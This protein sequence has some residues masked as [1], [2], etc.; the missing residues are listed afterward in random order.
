LPA[1]EPYRDRLL[2]TPR[3]FFAT[4]QLAAVVVAVTQPSAFCEADLTIQPSRA[5]LRDA[6]HEVLASSE[7]TSHPGERLHRCHS[8]GYVEF[9]N[10][11]ILLAGQRVSIAGRP[12]AEVIG[13]DES[14]LPDHIC[15]VVR[16]ESAKQSR[17]T[18]LA[19]TGQ[20][21]S[22]RTPAE[23]RRVAAHEA[24]GP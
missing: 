13:F 22:F 9:S 8:V 5:V 19:I 10:S 3:P 15:I 16:P 21:L 23:P 11:G 17:S 2:D 14:P 24:T 20:Q 7:K 12:W 1:A 18:P 4:R 6:V